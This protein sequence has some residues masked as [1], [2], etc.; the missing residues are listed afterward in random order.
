[1]ELRKKIEVEACKAD[2][3]WGAAYPLFSRVINDYGLKVGV[4]IGMAFGGHSDAMLRQT[5]LEKLYGVDPYKHFDGYD[6][7]MNLPQSEY[8][9]LHEF[10]VARLA[11][12]G[13]RFELIREVS[14]LAAARI[15][16]PLDFVYIDAVHTYEGV[17][18][19]LKLWFPKIRNGG[20]VAGHDDGL[21]NF[22]GVK[23][24]LDE[25]FLRFGWVVHE[26]G[27]GVWWVEKSPLN[28]S[29]I[30]P[31]Y[32]C[33][34]T[35]TDTLDS[36]FAGNFLEGDEVVVVNDCSKD[37][38]RQ[39]LQRYSAERHP[40]VIVEH[41]LNKGGASAR[42][43]AV[44]SA[45]N[46]LI[47]CLD[48]DNILKPNSV[49]QLREFLISECAHAAAFQEL[50]YFKD[51][52]GSITHRWVFSEG[53]I[54]LEDC[55]ASTVVPI[56][57]GN[58]LYTKAS[59]LGARGYPE[60]AHALDAWGF[61]LRQLASGQ[62]MVVLRDSGYFHRHGHDSYWAREDRKGRTSLTALQVLL[63]F[64]D[65]LEPRS[66]NYA[67]GP[68]GRN[69]WFQNM[70]AKPLR[71]KSRHVGKGGVV[72]DS[73][74]NQIINSS[75]LQRLWVRVREKIQNYRRV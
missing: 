17:L 69:R 29:F 32:N 20:I 75:A 59:W 47:F 68:R 43:T 71:T 65:Q 74:G 60:F 73:R 16:G 3:G 37:N 6:D 27:E 26:E 42:N 63:P 38:T 18:D 8:D 48:S 72:L 7:P 30:V 33:E 64:I 41:S 25:F 50:W 45:K 24:A 10:T 62:K 13:A 12:Y 39:I 55:L 57:S 51:D 28:V 56:S 49:P 54:T 35:I 46:S 5:Q 15:E 11:K 70:E 44:E 34:T 58:Y 2:Q 36:I 61:G 40:L 22:P 21:I 19:E 14:E 67:L 31:A 52:P 9:V 4:E 1:M 23:A 53:V 66:V